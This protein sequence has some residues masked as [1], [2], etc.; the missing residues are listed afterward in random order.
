MTFHLLD[1]SRNCTRTVTFNSF[2]D[3]YDE[4]DDHISGITFIQ[5]TD[6]KKYKYVMD[7]DKDK[8]LVA[9]P[10][11]SKRFK[12]WSEYNAFKIPVNEYDETAD[13]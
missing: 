7:L 8:V 13:L 3:F 5:W 6:D 12:T 9:A 10:E 2:W 1:R 11:N 4:K